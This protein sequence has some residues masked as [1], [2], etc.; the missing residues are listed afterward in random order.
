MSQQKK[1]GTPAELREL[2]KQRMALEQAALEREHEEVKKRLEEEKKRLEEEWKKRREEQEAAHLIEKSKACGVQQTGAEEADHV[3][4]GVSNLFNL[5]SGEWIVREDPLPARVLNAFEADAFADKRAS[6]AARR[7]ADDALRKARKAKLKG[8]ANVSFDTVVS[9]VE[10]FLGDPTSDPTTDGPPPLRGAGEV[11]RSDETDP[12]NLDFDED[13]DD[14][15]DSDDNDTQDDSESDKMDTHVHDG[16]GEGLPPGEVARPA[17]TGPQGVLTAP[18]LAPPILPPPPQAS[19][20]VVESSTS[21]V[22]PAADST[23]PAPFQASPDATLVIPPYILDLSS[24]SQEQAVE[25]V[26]IFNNQVD[27]LNERK[28]TAIYH[29]KQ[30]C[31]RAERDALHPQAERRAY[32]PTPFV[33]DELLEEESEIATVETRETLQLSKIM[34][35]RTIG[36]TADLG[37]GT[38]RDIARGKASNQRKRR[39][40]GAARR[41]VEATRS[42]GSGSDQRQTPVTQDPPQHHPR[43]DRRANAGG[44]NIRVEANEKRRRVS[45]GGPPDASASLSS[46]VMDDPARLPHSPAPHPSHPQRQRSRDIS[47]IRGPVPTT[48]TTTNNQGGLLAVAASGMPPPPPPPVNDDQQRRGEKKANKK[49]RNRRP[50][51]KPADASTSNRSSTSTASGSSPSP[52]PPQSPEDLL[53]EKMLAIAIKLPNHP[54]SREIQK[55]VDILPADFYPNSSSMDRAIYAADHAVDRARLARKFI[56]QYNFRM[57]VVGEHDAKVAQMAKLLSDAQK[58]ADRVR[59]EFSQPDGQ[60]PSTSGTQR[61]SASSSNRAPPSGRNPPP[62][63]SRK[64]DAPSYRGGKGGRGK[65]RK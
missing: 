31:L 56:E 1:N 60:T 54:R 23:V 21:Q 50:I 27:A 24:I 25:L 63:H 43:E 9:G 46:T 22:T 3:S 4:D 55:V 29:D 41:T 39:R 34:T 11:E 17:L 16:R 35:I 59:A 49:K 64:D 61:H 57:K 14:D 42:T 5:S 40:E 20:A 30:R 10:A 44:D 32:V 62:R 48:T 8:A 19:Q 7:Q 33:R 53:T 2:R 36:V 15:D 37:N 12:D 45:R 47:P 6:D 26:T 51:R 65:G 52:R 58:E 28:H 38:L 13:D 18:P